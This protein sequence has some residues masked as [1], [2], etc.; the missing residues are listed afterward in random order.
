MRKV[1]V[2][3]NVIISAAISN[4]GKPAEIVSMVLN[5]AVCLYYSTEIMAEYTDVLSRP[6]LKLEIAKQAFLL[7]G[8]K[9]VG[10]LITPLVSTVS[11]PDE[12]D[13]IF[14]DTAKEAGAILVTGNIKDYPDEDFIITP[15]KFLEL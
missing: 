15:A 11:M 6:K 13:R 14:Y 1:V 7:D 12:S 2:D 5:K 10:M 4:M 8:I 9:R 3:T